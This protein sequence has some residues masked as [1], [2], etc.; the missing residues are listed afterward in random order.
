M[1][2]QTPE[3]VIDDSVV[4]AAY[5]AFCEARMGRTLSDDEHDG[6]RSRLELTWIKPTITA[7]LRAANML[8]EP[9]KPN[10]ATE[11]IEAQLA[12]AKAGW[13]SALRIVNQ[14]HEIVKQ[15]GA[16]RDA[17]LARIAELEKS[18]RIVERLYKIERQERIEAEARI[19]EAAK[20]PAAANC[21]FSWRSA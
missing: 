21:M 1:T 17:A 16:E 14:G 3:S 4:E 13:D 11:T 6:L 5:R 18:Y 15:I 10:A 20:H 7:A 8:R 2:N 12:N 19:A 9:G